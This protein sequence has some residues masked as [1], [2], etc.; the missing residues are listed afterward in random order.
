VDL[1]KNSGNVSVLVP[2]VPF[3]PSSVAVVQPGVV[4]VFCDA[5]IDKADFLAE[6]TP[7]GLYKG[8]GYVPFNLIT[9]A[10]KADTTSQPLYPF[11][12]PKDSPFGGTL[13]V[14]VDHRRAWEAG[15]RYYRVLIDGNPRLEV[16]NDLVLNLGN[17]KYDI[18][19]QQAP[20]KFGSANGFYPVHDPSKVYYNT[21]L[22]CLLASTT[23][24][25]ALHTITVQF[26]SYSVVPVLKQTTSHPLLID[27][28]SCVASLEMPLLD[29]AHAQP[30]CGVLAYGD[31]SHLVSLGYM[32]SH[33]N[34]FGTYSFSIVKGAN[35]FD[36]LSGA[37]SPLPFV[38]QK[39]VA[40]LLG[41]CRIAA[42]AEYLYVAT[43]VINGVGRQS[44]YDA[45]A[46]VAFCLAP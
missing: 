37:V 19:E 30:L 18:I 25:N 35:T 43:S 12:F 39:S 2:G 24:T 36:S 23:E 32:A 45:S 41:T 17:G 29:G 20:K 44:Q 28:N 16:W 1:S 9:P 21:D 33:P 40:A 27:N 6:F 10:G 46:V 14:L 42:Y 22:G 7:P 5:E 3:R 26:Y 11:Q 8:I 34:N 31:T 15:L 13:P 38:Y 4:G